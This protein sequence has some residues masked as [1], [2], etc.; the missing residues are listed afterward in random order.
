M[1]GS[2]DRERDRSFAGRIMRALSPALQN[3]PSQAKEEI[4]STSVD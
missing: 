3:D 2:T 4:A 1:F